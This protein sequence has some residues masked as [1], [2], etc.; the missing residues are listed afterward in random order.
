[1]GILK[2]FG[3]VMGYVFKN[4]GLL[5]GILEHTLAA[6]VGIANITAST[7]DDKAVEKI[8]KIFDKIKKVLYT[9]SNFF[10]GKIN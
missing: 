5:T 1:M 2:L 4:L 8:K 6:A 10:S 7:R 9:I 3:R